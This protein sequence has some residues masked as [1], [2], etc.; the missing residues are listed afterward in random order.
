VGRPARFPAELILDGALRVIAANG[1]SAATAAAVAAE[2]G[3]PSGSIYHRFPTRDLLLARLWVRTV[4]R[5]QEVFL[6][7]LTTGAHGPDRAAGDA[8]ASVPRWCREHLDEA[9]VLLLH[10]RADL[11]GRW[12]VE[13]DAELDS[14]NTALTGALTGHAE[15]RF[16]RAG[17][18]EL[19]RVTFALVDVPHAAVRR[20]LAAGRPPPPEVDDLVREAASALL[21][22]TARSPLS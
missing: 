13:L 15:R 8:A 14:A 6:A 16:G 3:A 5:F 4:A 19:E 21:R 22:P 10:R 7:A 2:L 11:V 18:A 1:P 12:P 17:R 9:R 20:H